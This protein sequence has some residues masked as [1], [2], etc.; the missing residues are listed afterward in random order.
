MPQEGDH[1][2][3]KR[4]SSS[5]GPYRKGTMVTNVMTLMQ[6]YC[7]VK[8]HNNYIYSPCRWVIPR[9]INRQNAFAFQIST[10]LCKLVPSM[11]LSHLT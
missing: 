10:K 8:I 11:K 7:V 1:S 5:R 3:G 6:L 4:P 2:I 9:Q